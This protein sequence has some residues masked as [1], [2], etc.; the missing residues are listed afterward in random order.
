MEVETKLP[1]PW[2]QR[3]VGGGAGLSKGEKWVQEQYV[4]KVDFVLA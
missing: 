3:G 1:R 4:L 2:G